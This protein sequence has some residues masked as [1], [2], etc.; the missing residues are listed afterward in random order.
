MCVRVCACARRCVR[1]A[2]IDV[3]IYM[4]TYTCVHIYIKY[5]CVC[6]YVL[7]GVFGGTYVC[8]YIHMCVCVYVLRGVFGGSSTRIRGHCYTTLMCA[9]LRF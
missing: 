5:I 8:V 4:F 7:G 3:C 9:W 1:T 2:T 6:V